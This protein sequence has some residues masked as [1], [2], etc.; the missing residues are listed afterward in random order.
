[1]DEVYRRR[2]CHKGFAQSRVVSEDDIRAILKAGMNAPS[3][4]NSQPWEFL[5][6]EDRGALVKLGNI[7]EWT[8]ACAS[9]SHVV[10][11]LA[12][13]DEGGIQDINMGICAENIML[14]ATHLGIGS[15]IMGIHPGDD[16][17][18]ET[19]KMM[20]AIP[21]S[22]TAY[23]M[24]ALGYPAEAQEPNNRWI[25]SKVHRGQF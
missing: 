5:V 25:E 10:I 4:E 20:F 6:L 15:L 14:E 8:N 3:A 2:S 7:H 21:D 23:T 12:E 13:P 16:Q 1:M 18:Q 17:A 24:I 9:A 11:L 22:Y 19:I